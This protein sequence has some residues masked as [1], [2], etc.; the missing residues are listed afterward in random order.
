MQEK[1]P[2]LKKSRKNSRQNKLDIQ[3]KEMGLFSFDKQF[4]DLG[5]RSFAGIDEAGRGPWAGPVVAAAVILPQDATLP[6]LNDSKKVLP[7][8]RED[9][10]Q[11]INECALAVGVGIVGNNEIDSKNILQATLAAM[12][13]ALGVLKITPD[14]VLIDGNMCLP[15]I[16]IRQRSIVAGD[17]K[18]AAI[19]AASIIAKVTRDRIMIEFAKQFPQYGF[20]KHKGYGTKEHQDALQNF[21]PCPIH[22]KSFEPVG[23]L[24]EQKNG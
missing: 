8:K 16:S 13:Q 24:F 14:L 9:L 12:S 4:Y 5:F 11:K 21:G 3:G 18:S 19:A 20:E 1:P 15:G 23:R 10:F 17:A 6:G 7:K 22:R 2:G